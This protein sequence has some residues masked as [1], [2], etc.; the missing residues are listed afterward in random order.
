MPNKLKFYL[1]SPNIVTSLVRKISFN[2]LE[3]ERGKLLSEKKYNSQNQLKEETNNFYNDDPNRF[4]DKIRAINY[5]QTRIGRAYDC[6]GGR[7]NTFC[8]HV[9]DLDKVACYSIYSHHIFLKK[10]ENTVY[11]IPNNSNIKTTTDYEYT[12]IEN[13]HHLA[14]SKTTSSSNEVTETKFFLSHNFLF[15][16]TVQPIF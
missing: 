7:S 1:S 16:N 5:V 2:S 13:H 6:S 9:F 11:N 8:N 14:S 4:S 10:T 12:N 3:C 15:P